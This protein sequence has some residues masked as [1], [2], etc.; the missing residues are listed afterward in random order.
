MFQLHKKKIR[1][2]WEIKEVCLPKCVG[3]FPNTESSDNK[4]GLIGTVNSKN[5]L[6]PDLL[7]NKL[8]HF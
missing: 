1:L 8:R 2:G 5:W 4:Y 7:G 6:Y 3:I